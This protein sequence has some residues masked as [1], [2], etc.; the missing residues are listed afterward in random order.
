MEVTIARKIVIIMFVIFI[1][2]GV[3]K[4]WEWPW[5]SESHIDNGCYKDCYSQ[6]MDHGTSNPQ[7]CDQ[8]CAPICQKSQSGGYQIADENNK[9]HGNVP[10]PAG[11]SMP[12]A[13]DNNTTNEM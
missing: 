11:H 13:F 2:I 9:S 6:C 3:G 8:Q 5:H 4:S 1:Y 12:A 7:S 10:K